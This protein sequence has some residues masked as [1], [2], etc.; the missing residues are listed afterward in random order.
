MNHRFG[1]AILFGFLMVS[2]LP[3]ACMAA[4]SSG[5]VVYIQGGNSSLSEGSNGS[6]LLTV[7][8]IVP[9]YY[10]SI[11]NTSVL[12]PID[13]FSRND[14]PFTGAIVFSRTDGETVSLVEVANLS[15]S[16]GNRTLTVRVKPLEYYDGTTLESIVHDTTSLDTVKMENV[17][18]T[19]IYIEMKKPVPENM[20]LSN[21]CYYSDDGKHCYQVC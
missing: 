2:L 18:Q 6:S 17:V 21:C 14:A 20:R 3:G 8:D 7:E 11:A 1:A 9:Y 16:D 15:L 4:D 5:F 19:G 13:L 12:R 10:Y